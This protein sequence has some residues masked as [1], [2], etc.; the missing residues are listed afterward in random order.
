[1]DLCIRGRQLVGFMGGAVPVSE[2][3]LA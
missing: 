1:V 3:A 2:R